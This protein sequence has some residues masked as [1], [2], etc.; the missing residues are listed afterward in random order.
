MQ[1]LSYVRFIDRTIL[2]SVAIFFNALSCEISAR[3]CFEDLDADWHDL[4]IF[5]SIIEE[6]FRVR[7]TQKAPFIDTV[8]DVIKAVKTELF[9]KLSG[10]ELRTRN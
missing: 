8:G 10:L 4:E 6:D 9:S 5:L 3:T 7:I 1:N 2:K